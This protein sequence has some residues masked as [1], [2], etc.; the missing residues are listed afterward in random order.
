MLAAANDNIE[1]HML[2]KHLP[3]MF[4]FLQDKPWLHHRLKIEALYRRATEQQREE[5]EAVRRNEALIIPDSI[6]YAS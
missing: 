4:S 3:E 5:V 2:I 6:D 1:P